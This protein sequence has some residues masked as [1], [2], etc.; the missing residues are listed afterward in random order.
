MMMSAPFVEMEVKAYAE[1][2]N[3]A[4]SPAPRRIGQPY[5]IRVARSSRSQAASR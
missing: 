4:T 3:V 1:K 5:R 2:K